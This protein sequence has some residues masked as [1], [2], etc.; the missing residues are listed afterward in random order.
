[1]GHNELADIPIYQEARR[2]GKKFIRHTHKPPE[3]GDNCEIRVAKGLLDGGE[4]KE[5]EDY[6]IE[7]DIERQE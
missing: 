3:G 5:E 2:R 4:T 7:V 6:D 1:M